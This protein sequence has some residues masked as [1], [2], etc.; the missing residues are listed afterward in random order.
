M[1]DALNSISARAPLQTSLGKLTALPQTPGW[2][3]GV[4]RLRGKGNKKKKGKEK[5][6]NR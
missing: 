5:K 6:G 3:L 2:I 1:H 4:L